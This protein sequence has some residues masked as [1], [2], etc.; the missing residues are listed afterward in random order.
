MHRPIYR[1]EVLDTGRMVAQV[2]LPSASP[3]AC[4]R[5]GSAGSRRLAKASAAL[6]ACRLLHG[7]GALNDHLLPAVL[8][9]EEDEGEVQDV[10]A[11][12]EDQVPIAPR[13][14]LKSIQLEWVSRMWAGGAP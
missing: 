3:L 7:L 13:V 6:E 8:Q 12:G 11:A 9:E 1:L 5:G 4:A 10:G 14:Q 2:Q